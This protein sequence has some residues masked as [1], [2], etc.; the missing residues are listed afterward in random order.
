MYTGVVGVDGLV[1]DA[2]DLQERFEEEPNVSVEL[3]GIR[4]INL[5]VV[6]GALRNGSHGF[7]CLISNP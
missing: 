7:T 3:D 2:I 6:A 4:C 5:D 1:A